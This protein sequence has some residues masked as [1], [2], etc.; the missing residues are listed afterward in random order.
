MGDRL[1]RVTTGV[2]PVLVALTVAQQVGVGRWAFRFRPRMTAAVAIASGDA[3]IARNVGDEVPRE[4][5]VFL[6]DRAFFVA[7]AHRRGAGLDRVGPRPRLF[8]LL[9]GAVR[10]IDATGAAAIFH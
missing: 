7:V 8:A 1:V 5:L 2:S 3:L 9:R 6:I 4:L 10:F